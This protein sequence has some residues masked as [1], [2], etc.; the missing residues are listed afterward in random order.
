MKANTGCG[1]TSQ[2]CL[3]QYRLRL[4]PH[5]LQRDKSEAMSRLK[6]SVRKGLV[7]NGTGDFRGKS[8]LR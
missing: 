4:L 7:N 5:L 3:P 2:I 6:I 8:Q 1:P